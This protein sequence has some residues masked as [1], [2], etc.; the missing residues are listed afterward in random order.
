M[1]E[2]LLPSPGRR[3]GQEQRASPSSACSHLPGLHGATRCRN[4]GTSGAHLR[5]PH[6]PPPAAGARFHCGGSLSLQTL[7]GSWKQRH[8]ELRGWVRT[9]V[10]IPPA[11]PGAP[12]EG[13]ADTHRDPTLSCGGRAGSSPV[14]CPAS[15]HTQ[16]LRVQCWPRSPEHSHPLLPGTGTS[17]A[18]DRDLAPALP[19]PARQ[20]CREGTSAEMLL[21]SF[22]SP[23]REGGRCRSCAGAQ[24]SIPLHRA[25]GV[26]GVLL[27][28][29]RARL[30]R[31][32]KPGLAAALFPQSSAML[33]SQ[34]GSLLF[35]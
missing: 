18:G 21:W 8:T 32:S 4:V 19:F 26:G 13:T 20:G 34:Q 22:T 5:V 30:G 9:S 28:G 7:G 3:L 2:E 23:G 24:P 31:S 6:L 29:A 10:P 14:P 15:E 25:N 35:K 16:L 11:A 12:A 17:P 33:P 27:P 1:P